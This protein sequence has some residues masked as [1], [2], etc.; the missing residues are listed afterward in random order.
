[1]PAT[2]GVIIIT[3]TFLNLLGTTALYRVTAVDIGGK[4][5]TQ[6]IFRDALGVQQGVTANGADTFIFARPA[7][8]AGDAVYS[9]EAKT[10]FYSTVLYGLV[11][12][13]Q[14]AG[15][16]G[17]TALPFHFALTPDVSGN[18]W[19]QPD[20][21]L[22][23]GS[24]FPTAQVLIFGGAG[25]AYVLGLVLPSSYSGVTPQ[26]RIY[27]KAGT[28]GDV[29]FSLSYCNVALGALGTPTAFDETLTCTGTNTG[30]DTKNEAVAVCVTPTLV[31][32]DSLYVALAV[33]SGPACEVIGVRLEWT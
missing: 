23:A 14:F 9:I 30:G 6:L 12:P 3:P 18:V 21:I 5:V 28:T 20:V 1:M 19:W 26:F 27:F 32:G 31:A 16:G 25:S 11:I 2:A 22:H 29:G 4:K 15:G 7:I 17:A 10:L 24:L 33:T 13:E 8:G